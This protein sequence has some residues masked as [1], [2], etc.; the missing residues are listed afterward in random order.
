M[1]FRLKSTFGNY[2]RSAGILGVEE[3]CCIG[4]SIFKINIKS[5]NMVLESVLFG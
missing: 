1:L 4:L 5:L 3:C 2:E